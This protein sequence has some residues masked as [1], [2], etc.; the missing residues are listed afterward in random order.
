MALV[1]SLQNISSTHTAAPMGCNP[2]CSDSPTC[3]KTKHPGVI[4]DFVNK[5]RK[6]PHELEILG[7]GKQTKSYFDV[8]DC[9]DG[10]LNIPR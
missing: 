10:L 4:P 5:L 8:T 2:G 9:V 3:R 7:D 1:K 6:N